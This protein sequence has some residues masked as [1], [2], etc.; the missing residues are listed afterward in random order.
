MSEIGGLYRAIDWLTDE[1]RD[2]KEAFSRLKDENH[3]LKEKM[4][5]SS[6]DYWTRAC[7]P[8]REASQCYCQG[9]LF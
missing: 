2:M 5:H 8:L 7:F 4:K 6:K 9:A 1:V 3:R